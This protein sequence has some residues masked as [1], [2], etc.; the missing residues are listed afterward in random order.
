MKNIAVIGGAGYIGSHVVK[1][2]EDNGFV[3]HVFDNLNTGLKENIK[4]VKFTKGDILNKKELDLFFKK[5]KFSAVIHLAAL[6]AAGESMENPGIYS[7]NNISGTINVLNAMK[8]NG[9]SYFIFSSSA[10]VYGNPEFLPMDESHTT[11]PINYYGFTK[12]TIENILKWYDELYG[13]KHISLRYFN[14]VGYDVEGRIKGKEINPQN[15]FPIIME[16]INGE[17]ECLKIY[18]T[19]YDTKDGTCI[20][21]YIHVNDL[22]DAHLKS[23]Y[24]IFKSNKSNIFNLSTGEGISVKECVNKIKEIVGDFNVVEAQRRPGDPPKLYADNLK[25]KKLLEWKPKYSDLQTI[26]K[27]MYEV[28]KK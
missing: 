16:V 9:I 7:E 17:R 3:P 14:A 28:Y 8:N 20:R 21:D 19:D 5:E 23:L 15:L 25:A 11:K 10:A 26:I 12:L 22:A 1:E 24:Y 2:L 13:I 6:K 18:G 4:N 27:T